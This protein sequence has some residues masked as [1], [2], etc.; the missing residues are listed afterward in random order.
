MPKKIL[1]VSY[2]ANIPGACQSEW[3]DD[4]I[5]SLLAGKNEIILISSVCGGKNY[6]KNYKN[7]R[8]PSLSWFDF[9]S[10]L[11]RIKSDGGKIDLYLYL[12]IPFIFIFG[13]L[14]DCFQYLAT[15]GVGDGKWSWM[16]TSFFAE[17][18]IIITSPIDIILSTGGPASGHLSAILCSKLF[19]IPTVIELQDPLSGSDIGRNSSSAGWLFR[20]EKFI[21]KYSD[22]TVYVTEAAADFARKQFKSNKIEGIYPGSWDFDIRPDMSKPSKPA[23][24]R[25]IHL[26]SL[27][28]TRNLTSI[29]TAID[30]LISEGDYD[31]TN[32]ELLNLGHV[33]PEIRSEIEK[34]TYVKISPP[35]SRI[36]ALNTASNYDVM[37][38]IQNKDERSQ[39]TIPYKTYDYLNIKN[40]ILALLNSNELTSMMHSFGH[41][42]FELHD[43]EEIKKGLIS[44]IKNNKIERNA[45]KIICPV[46]QAELLIKIN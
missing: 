41:M 42:A 25:M 17:L 23:I 16:F 6:N 28:S 11:Q 24:F 14:I 39:V 19:R 46:I 44:L 45:E 18:Y 7:I 12:L 43:V 36:E 2:Y 32:F 37:L 21:V 40:N 8:V 35:V 22:K 33:S 13:S 29:I 20:V 26:G 30:M 1:I 5:K 27:Y 3:V 38:L 15:K 4:K 9:K 31:E 10:E 34:K